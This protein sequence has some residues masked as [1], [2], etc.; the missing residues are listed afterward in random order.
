MPKRKQLCDPKNCW[1]TVFKRS[2]LLILDGWGIGKV[3]ESDAIQQANTP[4]Y[5]QLVE[6]FPN[7]ELL[8]HGAYVGLPDGQMG[9]SEVGH[10]NLGAGRIVYQDLVKI[11]KAIEDHS[12]ENNPEFMQLINY[13]NNNQKPCHLIGLLSDGGVHSHISHVFGII[14]LLE[15]H[16]KVPVYL[17]VITD[18]RDTDPHSGMQFIN[19]TQE[20]LNGKKTQ[21]ASLIGRYYAMD[22]D[23]R[24]E[25]IRKAYELYVLGKGTK[26]SNAMQALETSYASGITDEFIEPFRIQDTPESLIKNGDA[27]LCINFR[28]DRLRQLTQVFTQNDQPE[29]QMKK[30]QLHFVTMARYD[31]SFEGV[32]VLF[33]KTDLQNT[34]GEMLSR[35][36]CTQVRIAETEK[37]PHVSFFFSG[38]RE[39]N[40]SGEK[41]ILVASPKVPTY[42]LKP[43]MSA[44]ALAE[45]TIEIIQEELPDFIC[46]NFANADMVGHTGVFTAEIKAAE[47]VDQCLEKIIPEALKRDYAILILADHGNGEFMINEDG[48]PNTAHTKNPV[49]C[50]LVS[51]KKELKIQNG[52]LADIAPTLLKLMALPIPVEMD[53]KV[54]VA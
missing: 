52:I 10:I 27:V 42:D 38:G 45:K 18:G 2:L 36:G 28:T 26:V 32:S 46:L 1:N 53:G 35:Y 9:N 25:R 15:A 20:F 54:L 33:D 51:N 21:I 8:T 34:L 11:N 13:C 31:H 24:W 30:M 22:R 39:K 23:K 12:L 49:P 14:N 3:P 17:H 7:S 4:F 44:N 19:Q 50:I 16:L 43:E 5:D 41:R 47:T 37:Y 29:Y 40:F 6:S 48:S